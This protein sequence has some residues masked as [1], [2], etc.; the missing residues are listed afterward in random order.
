MKG[1]R[2]HAC[3]TCI[4]FNT[5]RVDGEMTYYCGRLKYETKPQYQFNCWNPTEVVKKLMEKE[6]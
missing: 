2:F 1:S 4:H 5:A 3:A 6:M